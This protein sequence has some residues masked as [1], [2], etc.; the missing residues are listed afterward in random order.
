MPRL[1]PI[2]KV[3]HW[4]RQCITVYSHVYIRRRS[5]NPTETSPVTPQVLHRIWRALGRDDMLVPSGSVD[6]ARSE[7]RKLHVTP[8]FVVKKFKNHFFKKIKK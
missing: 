2:S 7:R 4:L 3:R 8:G 1:S 6:G 5:E